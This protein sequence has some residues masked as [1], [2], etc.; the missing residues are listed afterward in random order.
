MTVS[1]PGLPLR[2]RK[3]RPSSP[4]SNGAQRG[5]CTP[6]MYRW[7][8]SV[9]TAGWQPSCGPGRRD[10]TRPAF[11]QSGAFRKKARK[12]WG[13]SKFGLRGERFSR[14]LSGGGK[15]AGGERSRR[16]ESKPLVRLRELWNRSDYARLRSTPPGRDCGLQ[17]S[18]LS[19]KVFESWLIGTRVHGDDGPFAPHGRS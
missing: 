1:A 9:P 13:F 4:A 19:A 11:R 3:R 2:W 14:G 12:Y 15:G 18:P 7:A 16:D 6:I 10:L 17:V 5:R 8:I